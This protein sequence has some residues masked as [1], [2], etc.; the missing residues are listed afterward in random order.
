MQE[1]KKKKK[2]KN[3]TA[4]FKKPT[5]CFQKLRLKHGSFGVTIPSEPLASY[6]EYIKTYSVFSR[7]SFSSSSRTFS[8]ITSA[9][10]VSWADTLLATHD[11]IQLKADSVSGG[12]GLSVNF[13]AASR[14]CMTYL[15]EMIPLRM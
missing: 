2:K 11:L 9:L 6:I 7:P 5:L 12:S 8:S 1:F 10:V 14:I 13:V 15:V 4:A 3:F